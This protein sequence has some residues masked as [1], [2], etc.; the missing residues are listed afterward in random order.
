MT[1]TLSS[2]R[3]RRTA[4]GMCLLRFLA[5]GIFEAGVFEAAAAG[6]AAVGGVSVFCM[7]N[8][9]RG[10]LR[11]RPGPRPGPGPGPRPRPAIIAGWRRRGVAVLRL[12]HWTSANTVSIRSVSVMRVRSATEIVADRQGRERRCRARLRMPPPTPSTTTDWAKQFAYCLSRHSAVGL[13]L[14]PTMARSPAASGLTFD[15]AAAG[16]AAAGGVAVFCMSNWPRGQLRPGPGPR[17]EP[18]PAISC[19]A[20]GSWFASNS[21]ISRRDLRPPPRLS[22]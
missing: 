13:P 19:W 11:P 20:W 17:P 1:P 16:G 2:W 12:P 4:W 9:P 5:A 3:K 7:S 22:A 8:W 14:C 10:Q 15:P 21:S 18:G 6:G